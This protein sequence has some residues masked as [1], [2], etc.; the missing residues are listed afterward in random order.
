MNL[1]SCPRFSASY[2]H[3][4]LSCKD[5]NE[6]IESEDGIHTFLKECTCLLGLEIVK[7]VNTSEQ[8]FSICDKGTLHFF[9]KEKNFYFD[10]CLEQN[11]NLTEIIK[12]T[13]E[14]FDVSMMIQNNLERG[15]T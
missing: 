1:V 14:Y 15:V 12:H 4:L 13:R 11:T 5:A 7:Q 3:L 8:Y 6:K 10:I 9:K 2:F